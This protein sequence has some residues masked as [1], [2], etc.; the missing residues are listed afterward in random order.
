MPPHD[1]ICILVFHDIIV[2]KRIKWR[3]AKRSKYLKEK[4]QETE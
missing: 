2:H 1:K 3:P 4:R